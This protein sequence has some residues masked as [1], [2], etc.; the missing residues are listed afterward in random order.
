MANLT[1][2][3]LLNTKGSDVWT[4]APQDTVY[5]ALKVLSERNI[6]VLPVVD[7]GAL[8]GIFSERDYARRVALH[9]RNSKATSVSEVMTK[10]VITAAP[11]DT[12][13]HCM[14]IVVSKGFRHL[15]IVEESLLVGIISSTDLLAEVIRSKERQIGKLQEF[16]QGS[17][18][19][20]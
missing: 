3:T 8:V 2:Y 4:A 9:G 6:G 16:I 18:E 20:S 12:I 15:P 10:E 13:D 14:E 7:S 17:A 19:V 1:V 11:D 5:E